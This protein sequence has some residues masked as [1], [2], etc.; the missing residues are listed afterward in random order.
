MLYAGNGYA[1]FNTTSITAAENVAWL[2]T[3]KR[4]M[5]EYKNAVLSF[6]SAQHILK[7]IRH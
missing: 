2:D 4:N 3:P 6:R 5:N 7:S 1:E